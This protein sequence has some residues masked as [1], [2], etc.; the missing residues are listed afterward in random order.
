MSKNQR[1]D[2]LLDKITKGVQVSFKKFL[3]EAVEKNKEMVIMRNNKVVFCRRWTRRESSA[4]EI[5]AG[6]SLPVLLESCGTRSRI[7]GRRPDS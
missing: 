2:L 4:R 6:W 5:S 3:K 7:S 1:L